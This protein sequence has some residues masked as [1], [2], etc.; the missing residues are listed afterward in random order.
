MPKKKVEAPVAPVIPTAPKLVGLLFS[1]DWCGYCPGAKKVLSK[2]VEGLP[3]AIEVIKLDQGQEARALAS[4]LD[5]QG[6]P[7]LLVFSASDFS[8]AEG[9]SPWAPRL[10]KLAAPVAVQVGALNAAEYQ[11]FLQEA[12]GGKP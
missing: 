4:R 2:A 12:L 11:A 3:V 5:V 7:T 1:A 6:L 8:R 10:R 9:V